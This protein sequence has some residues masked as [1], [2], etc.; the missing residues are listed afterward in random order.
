MLELSTA[1]VG[2]TSALGL[3]VLASDHP[4]SRAQDPGVAR[5]AHSAAPTL[6]AVVESVRRRRFAWLCDR[7]RRQTYTVTTTVRPVPRS[8]KAFMSS[9]SEVIR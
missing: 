2:K 6:P 8:I 4:R 3:P 5:K 9:V 1:H 7:V